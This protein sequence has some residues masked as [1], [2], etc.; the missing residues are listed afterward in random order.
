MNQSRPFDEFVVQP[1]RDWRIWVNLGLMDVVQNYRRTFLG[2]IWLT[3]NV[4]IWSIAVSFVWSVLFGTT[5][6]EL[7]PY[8]T[9]GF[10]AWM[11]ISATITE[12]GATFQTYGQ[13][14]VGVSVR[15]SQ[16]IWT[17]AFKQVIVLVHH[18]VVFVG[19]ALLDLVPVNANSLYILVSLVLLFALSIPAISVMSI[20]FI[21]FRDLQKLAA[22]L[23]ILI[24]VTTPIF[25]RP[26]F[27]GDQP[28][29]FVY[30]PFYYIVEFL[31][32]PLLGEPIPMSVIAVVLGMTA[33]LWLI[34]FVFYKKYQQFV[35]YW[36]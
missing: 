13:Y 21:R 35:V 10:I 8:I 6:S 14:V 20:L 34:G 23:L 1:L 26:E 3:L 12:G 5:V 2:P 18:L 27:A 29:I 28:A 25:W 19:F 9:A 4:V 24:L 17:V 22:S 16:L 33:V 11:W 36:V 7:A 15:K 31:R 30:N 32:L